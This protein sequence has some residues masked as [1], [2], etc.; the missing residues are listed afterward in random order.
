MEVE[1]EPVIKQRSNR[2]KRTIGIY[3][4]ENSGMTIIAIGGLHGNE[5]AGVIAL[6]R[7]MHQLMDEEIP[8]KGRLVGLSGNLAAL[9]IGQ[10][11]INRDL[12]RVWFHHE[13]LDHRDLHGASEQGDLDEIN[14]IIHDELENRTGEAL[15]LDMHTTSS[16]SPPF[17]M[18]GDTIRNRKFVD[19]FPVPTILGVEE[20]LDGP[21]LSYINELG[22]LSI[23]FEAGQHDDQRSIYFQEALIWLILARAG[24][25]DPMQVPDFQL[26]WDT[27]HEASVG[28]LKMFEVRLRHGITE[29]DEFQMKQGY[30]NF[31]PVQKNEV[32]A[33]DTKGKI[34]LPEGGRIFMPLYQNQGDNGF[35]LIRGVRKF[36]LRLSLWMRR[37][38]IYHILPLLPG[39]TRIENVHTLAVNTRIAVLFGPEV[40]HLLGYRKR[41]AQGNVIVMQRRKY[42]FTPPPLP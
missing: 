40:F 37:L 26:H 13:G 17:L 27:L 39:I 21:L 7:V 38:N 28:L 24:C 29:K 6:E 20:Q 11:F 31:M 5:P 3:D 16:D 25:I 30:V 15:F 10:R 8:F 33:S 4:R 18:I 12:N 42:D 32:V 2:Y 23:G 1:T 14:K 19:G 34:Q 36:W 41:R 9:E 35:F 22:H